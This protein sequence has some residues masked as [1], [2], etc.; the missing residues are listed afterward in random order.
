MALA[1]MVGMTGPAV[2]AYTGWLADPLFPDSMNY[3]VDG[4]PCG[5][6]EFMPPTKRWM[7]SAHGGNDVYGMWGPT[8]GMSKQQLMNVVQHA[9]LV[10]QPA[11]Q[12][13]QPPPLTQPNG[14]HKIGPN[15]E[16]LGGQNGEPIVARIERQ[17][18]DNGQIFYSAQTAIDI[19]AGR[20]SQ[21]FL[22]ERL[23]I[24]YVMMSPMR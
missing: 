23:A 20:P 22:T 17:R 21:T 19:L 2:A 6:V 11:S 1:L 8:Y 14:W 3:I 24:E 13:Q 7:G 10:E 15:V 16:V 18:T 9:C 4:K 12:Q 5:N